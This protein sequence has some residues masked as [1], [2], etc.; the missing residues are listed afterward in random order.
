MHCNFK[1]E[2]F[3]PLIIWC[4]LLSKYSV[5]AFAAFQPA[6]TM[7]DSKTIHNAP[8][9]TLTYRRSKGSVHSGATFLAST[10]RGI[11]ASRYD[12][13]P[14]RFSSAA[15]SL[16]SLCTLPFCRSCPP[17]VSLTYCG[18]VSNPDIT[19]SSDDSDSEGSV[20]SSIPSKTSWKDQLLQFSNFASLLCVL[21]CTVLPI[22]TIVFPLM[23][24][25]VSASQLEWL[26]Q[27][28]H[29]VALGFVLPVGGLA[30][31]TNY[32]YNHKTKWIAALGCLGLLLVGSANAGCSLVPHGVGG[33]VGHFVHEL[34][35][36]LHH[37]I[38]HRVANLAGCALLLFSNYLSRKKAAE[39]ATCNGGAGCNHS[40]H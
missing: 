15:G 22:I 12:K 28:G 36:T 34:L 13:R 11:G 7:N 37:G 24:I 16:R 23:G 27:A 29:T 32:L 8:H 9:S 1:T 3:V 40:H 19:A 39:N 5:V 20:E 2:S 30:T 14:S 35:H 17:P 25:L 33:S 4:F 6:T 38:Q 10:P 31:V 18:M 21:D 26:H